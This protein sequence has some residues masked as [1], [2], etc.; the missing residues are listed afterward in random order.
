M[1]APSELCSFSVSDL[2]NTKEKGATDW[3]RN[4]NVKCHEHFEQSS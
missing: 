3:N 4:S 1:H 2:K